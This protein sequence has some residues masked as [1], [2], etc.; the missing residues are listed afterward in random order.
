M[1]KRNRVRVKMRVLTTNQMI[2]KVKTLMSDD[3]KPL[4]WVLTK[5]LE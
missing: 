3:S 2:R 5:S 1:I 4:K